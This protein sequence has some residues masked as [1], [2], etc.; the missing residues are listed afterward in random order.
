MTIEDSSNTY[1]QLLKEQG[2]Y[3]ITVEGV[4]WYDYNG[5]MIP[6]YLPHC[7]P[8]ITQE[9]A[10]KV[11]RKSGRPF[12]RWDSEFGGVAGSE[13]WYVIRRGRWSLEECSGNARSK[14]RRGHKHLHGRVLTTEEV[15]KLAYDVCKKAATRYEKTGF[16]PPKE[17]FDQKVQAAVRVNDVLEFFGVFSGDKLV[18]YSENYIQDNAAFWE[19]IWYDPEFL[20]KYSSYV[21][22]DEMLNY[23][24]NCKK[25][26]YVSD[27][28]RSIYHRTKVQEFLT[29]VFGFTKE[30]AV[31]NILYS[32]KFAMALK[33]AFPFRHISW[34][35][36]NKWT[37]NTLD[38]I[39]AILRQEHIRRACE[40][41]DIREVD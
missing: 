9:L 12:V 31:L 19:S 37:N 17:V 10:L 35:F 6:A 29:N 14:I 22:I 8:V 41:Q 4:D 33:V 7:C 11:L 28:S 5:F 25:F 32:P 30:Y 39:G 40:K 27:G 20:P 26:L 21:L 16:V 15:Y 23:Y 3:V 34:F 38:K 2:N 36:S 13:W 24:L 1:A 18:G